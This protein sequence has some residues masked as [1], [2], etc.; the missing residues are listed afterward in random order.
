ML[1]KII[2]AKPPPSPDEAVRRALASVAATT[3]DQPWEQGVD[4][5]AGVS[6]RLATLDDLPGLVALEAFWH[7]EGLKSDESTLRRRLKNH[8]TGQLVAVAPDGQLLGV[9]YSQRVPSYESLLSTTRARE[10]E[11]HTPT[12]PV[13][14][15]LAVL[16]RPEAKQVGDVIR[17]TMLRYGQADPTVERACGVTRCRNFDASSSGTTPAAYRAH[18]DEADDPGLLFHTMAGAFVCDLVA[19]YRPGDTQNLAYGVIISYEFRKA[20]LSRARA[21]AADGGRRGGAAA[22]AATGS[23]ASPPATPSTLLLPTTKAECESLVIEMIAPLTTE[24]RGVAKWDAERRHVGFMDLGIDSLD[25]Q[26]LALNLNARLGLR[27]N[28]TIIFE[29]PNVAELAGYILEQLGGPQAVQAAQARHQ[30][31]SP[32]RAQLSDHLLAHQQQHQQQ[33]IAS[34]ASARW[35]G[36]ATTTFSML[37]AGGDAVGQVPS[38]RWLVGAAPIPSGRHGAFLHHAQHFAGTFF[39]ISPAECSATDPQQRLLLEYGYEALHGADARRLELSGADMGVFLGIMNADF[40]ALFVE[41]ESVYAATGGTISIAAGRLSFVLG[42]QG[43]VA[44]YDTACSSG[45][46]ASHAASS[47]LRLAECASGL[48]LA[49]SLMLSPQVLAAAALAR[50]P[51]HPRLL[52]LLSLFLSAQSYPPVSI[53]PARRIIYT[54]APGCFPR[55]AGARPSTPAPTATH[56]AKASAPLSCALATTRPP[57]QPMRWRIWAAECDL[58]ARA[59]ASRHRAA[60]RRRAC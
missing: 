21:K 56:A 46:V 11:L 4:V 20:G 34:G 38:E 35:P 14:Q 1:K 40:N 30:S 23:A 22:G 44:S 32:P 2:G 51:S 43:P 26:K 7:N 52:S 18:V 47:A 9:M 41:N 17:R 15:L 53:C 60:R 25:A 36:S 6:I 59:R 19:N 45:L 28:D 49:V 10:L 33:Y 29:Q 50:T 54:P 31:Q 8:P 58:T 16:Q 55:T 57:R 39:G 24:T 37:P 48:V 12:G 13:I 3:G 27:L 5:P 42:S